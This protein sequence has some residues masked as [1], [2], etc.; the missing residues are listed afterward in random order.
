MC[1]VVLKAEITMNF[2][3]I[4]LTFSSRDQW[5]CSQYFMIMDINIFFAHNKKCSRFQLCLSY[6]AQI[7]RPNDIMGP[8]A[9]CQNQPDSFC[10]VG[11][12]RQIW[13]CA[14]KAHPD[15]PSRQGVNMIRNAGVSAC[16][17]VDM[18]N[19]WD[20]WRCVIGLAW[21]IRGEH[22]HSGDED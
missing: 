19:A 8:E 17:T 16:V 7:M 18:S 1:S 9:F 5:Q 22:R 21:E 13:T 12:K 4:Y 11:K 20:T 3:L 14:E 15:G 2:I 10:Y 6:S